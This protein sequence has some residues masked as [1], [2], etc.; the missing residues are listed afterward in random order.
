MVGGKEGVVRAVIGVA[1]VL[2]AYKDG[3][4]GRPYMQ[5]NSH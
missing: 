1:D 4:E 5:A 3:R 2:L